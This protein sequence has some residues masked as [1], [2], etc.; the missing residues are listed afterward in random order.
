MRWGRSG[1]KEIMN[2]AKEEG[3]REERGRMEWQDC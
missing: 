2:G 3:K 1:E